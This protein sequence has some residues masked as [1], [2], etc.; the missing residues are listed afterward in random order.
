M[1]LVIPIA[2][3]DPRHYSRAEPGIQGLVDLVTWEIWKWREDGALSRHLLPR[4]VQDLHRFDIL[5]GSHP[6]IPHLIPARTAMLENLAMFSEELMDTLL[7][8][9]S[10][11][12]AYLSVDN[13]TIIRHLRSATLRQE[14][15]PVLCGSAAKNIG[16]EL[17][18][19]YVGELLASPVDMQ[20]D[21]LRKDVPLR[22]LAWKVSWDKRKGW[23]TF[24][25]VY[26]GV[27]SCIVSVS[28]L[29]PFLCIGTLLRQSALL[30][31][32]RNQREKVSKLLL[33]YASEAEEVDELTVGSVGVI[34]GLKYTC[35]G[36]TLVSARNHPSHASPESLRDITSPPAVISASVIPQSHSD[37]VPVQEA[38]QSLAR[39]DP[40]VRIEN[41]EGQILVHGLGSLHLEIVESRLRDEWDARFEFGRRRVSFREG[42]N[43]LLPEEISDSWKTESVGRSVT[44]QISLSVRPLSEGEDGDPAWDGN[45]VVDKDSKPLPAADAFSDQLSPSANLARGIASTLTNSPHTSLPMSH[46]HLQVKDF[47]YPSGVS[48]SVLMGAS[49]VILRNH[50]RRLGMGPLMEPYVRLKVSVDDDSLGKAVKDLTE[51]GGEVLNLGLGSHP[52]DSRY[53]ESGVYIPPGWLSPSSIPTSTSSPASHSRRS[54]SAIAPLSKMLDYAKRLRALSGGHGV[55]EMANAG[56]REVTEGRKLEILREIGRS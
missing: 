25:R 23:M 29:N 3:F 31:T 42:V 32:T 26:S 22:L 52:E 49:S 30:N 1:A 19:D 27:R 53:S 28:T 41:Q 11:P 10:D 9:P 15:L 37:L 7:G 21:V 14:I 38:L 4:D 56:F 34:L 51:N 40:S 17:V 43:P 54:I 39:T 20:R 24:V 50:F 46:V 8:L 18:M 13:S 33:L 44:V 12:S 55:F 36:D 5:P 6:I 2:S 47:S 35:T 45:V 48:P 16:T